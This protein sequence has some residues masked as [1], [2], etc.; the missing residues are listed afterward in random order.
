MR[1]F[2]L[3]LIREGI[4][5]RDCLRTGE[6]PTPR[7]HVGGN[8]LFLSHVAVGDPVQTFKH[9]T[10]LIVALFAAAGLVAAALL[11]GRKRPA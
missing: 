11:T 4:I 9:A 8:E 10:L 7:I 3:A 6:C 2:Q 1:Q 5:V